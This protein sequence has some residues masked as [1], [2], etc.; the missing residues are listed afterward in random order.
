MDLFESK[1][2]Y[3]I[4]QTIFDMMNYDLI[5]HTDYDFNYEDWLEMQIINLTVDTSLD[6]KSFFT[7]PIL[8]HN[9]LLMLR[10]INDECLNECEKIP[11]KLDYDLD[12]LVKKAVC[13]VGHRIQENNINPLKNEFTLANDE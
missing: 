13:A 9:M 10:E 5:H 8:P 6:Y 12:F 2:L 1:I 3:E 4:Y 11:L 7:Q